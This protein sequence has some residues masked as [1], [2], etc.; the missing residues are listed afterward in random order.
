MSCSSGGDE[1]KEGRGLFT[2]VE[3]GNQISYLAGE[4]EAGTLQL[5]NDID[6]TIVNLQYESVCSPETEVVSRLY[7]G[8]IGNNL[9]INLQNQ[10]VDLSDTAQATRQFGF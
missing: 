4:L 3:D 2:L 1:L 9:E 10:L 5:A 6:L 7:A 8:G